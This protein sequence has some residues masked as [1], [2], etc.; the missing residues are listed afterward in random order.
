MDK[1]CILVVDD[2]EHVRKALARWFRIC[3]FDV[4][5]AD[6]GDVA[7]KMCTDTAYDIITMDL[8]MPR[9]GGV[10]AID[11]IKHLHPDVPIIVLTGFSPDS[12][13]AKNCGAAKILTKPLRLRD[14][15]AE[16]RQALGGAPDPQVA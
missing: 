1:P 3:G 15:E 2:E 5:V 6:D 7:V 11:A 9:M 14:L 16:V 12:E 8:E 13:E 10:E 4:D